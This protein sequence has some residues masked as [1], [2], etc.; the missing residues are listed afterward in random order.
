MYANML[1]KFDNVK[2]IVL[3]LYNFHEI[4]VNFYQL[5]K[6][7]IYTYFLWGGFLRNSSG[8]LLTVPKSGELAL[9]AEDLKRLRSPHLRGPDFRRVRVGVFQ[10]FPSGFEMGTLTIVIGNSSS[11]HVV[12][13]KDEL[14]AESL[15]TEA[16]SV[17]SPPGDSPSAALGLLA[18]ASRLSLSGGVTSTSVTVSVSVLSAVPVIAVVLAVMSSVTVT[19]SFPTV[20]GSAATRGV[21]ERLRVSSRLAGADRMA[22]R[23]GRG[24]TAV[25]LG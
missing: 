24:R 4:K 14:L 19:L 22:S 1:N 10:N 11:L 25:P 20:A 3:M 9:P 12:P 8:L 17:A 5:G 6:T 2:S 7:N 13:S 16:V 18:S 21:G 23:C 15:E